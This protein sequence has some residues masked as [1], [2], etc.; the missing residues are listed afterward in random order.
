MTLATARRDLT[1]M[2]ADLATLKS[3]PQL[4]QDLFASHAFTRASDLRGALWRP[5]ARADA[6]ALA[7]EYEALGVQAGAL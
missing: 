2:T 4:D 5:H 3:R 6:L 7:A 1:A